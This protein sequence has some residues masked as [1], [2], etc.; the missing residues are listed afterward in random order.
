[1][2]WVTLSVK[3][4]F[5]TVIPFFIEWDR[6]VTHPAAD[7]PQGCRLQTLTFTHPQP[8]RV[9]EMLARMGIDATVTTGVEGSL[10]ALLQTPK[11]ALE[12]R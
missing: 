9:R 4:E 2:R 6:T 10:M 5:E 7:S 12:L 1:M 3:T 8:A 11:G